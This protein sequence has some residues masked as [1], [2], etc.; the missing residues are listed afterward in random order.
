MQPANI[1]QCLLTYLIR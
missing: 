1:V